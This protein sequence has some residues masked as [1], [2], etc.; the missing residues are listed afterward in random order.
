MP[1]RNAHGSN[2]D[3]IGMFATFKALHDAAPPHLKEGFSSF[4]NA[5]KG[6]M[7]NC[8]KSFVDVANFAMM[9]HRNAKRK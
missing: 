2:P 3:L 5:A 1:P 9:L 7:K 4:M 6:I 8:P